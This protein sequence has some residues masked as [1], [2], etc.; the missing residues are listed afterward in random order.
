[1]V[2]L[3]IPELNKKLLTRNPLMHLNSR[4]DAPYWNLKHNSMDK[5]KKAFQQNNLE[6]AIDHC[7]NIVNFHAN[8]S[9]Q[10]KYEYPLTA[11]NFVYDANNHHYNSISQ[12]DPITYALLQLDFQESAN[13]VANFV[14][15]NYYANPKN[16]HNKSLV[17][18][19]M[20]E[21]VGENQLAINQAKLAQEWHV[22]NR[23]MS[24]YISEYLIALEKK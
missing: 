8:L 24:Q 2:E 23:E 21:S 20:L 7:C 12:A 16:Q 18:A 17:V 6:E 22:N 9:L 1:M 14:F 19:K 10:A 15:E 5:A 3:Y 13:A 4:N 11:N